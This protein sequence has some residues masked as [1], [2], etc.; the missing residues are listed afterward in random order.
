M[1]PVE[2][3]QGA[4]P[5]I[6]AFPHTG[7]EVPP[8]IGE[9]LNDEG[10]CLRD[11]DWH[12]HRLY[13]GLLPDA[14][15]V[16][17]TFHR[18][19]V[20]ANRDPTGAS[21]YPGQNTTGLVPATD[22][23]GAP[24]WR[25]GAAPDAAGIADRVA[26][27]HAPYHAALAAEIARVQARHGIAVLYDCHSIRSRIPFLFPGT[28]PDFNIGTDGGRTCDPAIERAAAE[29]CAAADRY[30]SIVNGRFRGGWTTRHYGR[31]EAGIHA[32]QME[33]AQNS[34]LATEAPPFA[35]D[36]AKA[37]RLRPVLGALLGR[38]AA[39]AEVLKG[40]RA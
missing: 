35:L 34:H 13:A 19:V 37:A 30:T 2:I 12:I 11:T 9:R 26:R 3:A 33:L 29:T 32:I 39:A 7:T 6:L 23:D 28:L 31:P 36:E 14:T 10:R 21:L 4:S 40:A 18:Y 16:R 17:A 25:D 27:F 22:F 38:L 8:D 24:I 1:S 5:V 20:D 15:T